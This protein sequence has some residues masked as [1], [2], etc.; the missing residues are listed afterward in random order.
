MLPSGSIPLFSEK[1]IPQHRS[2]SDTA[3]SPC[4]LANTCQASSNYQVVKVLTSFC[5][6]PNTRHHQGTQHGQEKIPNSIMIII[7]IMISIR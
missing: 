1:H 4:Q 7:I 2:A 5:F 3:P 6:P